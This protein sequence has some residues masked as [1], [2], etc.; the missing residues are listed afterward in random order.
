[1]KFVPDACSGFDPYL[2]SKIVG[3]DL[4]LRQ[5]SDAVCDHLASPSPR[6]P[7]VLSIHG[8]PG[9]GKSLFHQ[10]AARAL[11]S[12]AP[13]P[14]LRC[15]G[16]DCAGYKVL[17]GLDFSENDRQAQHAALRA[18][19]YDH[20]KL[21]TNG[22]LIIEEYDKL[23]CTMRGFFRHL[24]E[25]GEVGN[26]S[27]SRSIVVLESNTGYTSLHGMLKKAGKREKISSEDAQRELKDVVLKQWLAEDCEQRTD[28]LKMVRLVDFFLPFFPLEK[29]HI[30]SLFQMRL[31]GMA[32]DLGKQRLG[33]LQWDKSVVDFL[34]HKVD[35]EGGFPV[36]G[37]K[38]IG[39]LMTRH[40]SRPVREWAKLQE[41]RREEEL[42]VQ[43]GR[44][45]V[46]KDK[47]QIVPYGTAV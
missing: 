23:D 26:I 32:Q 13:H 12:T 17:F 46:V 27:L 38:E 14:D 24:L 15:P 25:G 3:Q 39:T 7:L 35:F 4:A 40:V 43:L 29:Q 36:E 41:N 18:S 31:K 21:T 9:V 30:E 20:M 16:P 11:Y 8:P 28:T 42:P 5:I 6:K 33:M 10:E 44:L 1:M 45:K 19:M 34:T 47:I 2:S 22:F 37:G